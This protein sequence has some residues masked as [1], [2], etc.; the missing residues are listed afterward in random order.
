MSTKNHALVFGA[1]GLAGWGLTN[2]LLNNYPSKG[3]FER[4]TA[5]ANR[6]LALED[7][8]WP[9]N[10]LD[11]PIL[12][13][14]AGVDLSRGSPEEFAQELKSKMHSLETVTHVY[15]FGDQY[16]NTYFRNQSDE[17]KL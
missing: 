3:I 4:V 17:I 7:T 14:I 11:G 5:C 16:Q 1:T 10:N 2:Q 8:M 15:Y 12:D 6:P 9:V 13:F